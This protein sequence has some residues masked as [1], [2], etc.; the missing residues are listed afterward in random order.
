MTPQI[1]ILNGLFASA[2]GFITAA[3]GAGVVAILAVIVLV[4]VGA[5]AIRKIAG[6]VIVIAILAAVF[7][8]MQ[9]N[10][11]S[12]V[13]HIISQVQTG[14]G[15]TLDPTQAANLVKNGKITIQ[16]GGKTYDISMDTSGW[17][18]VPKVVAR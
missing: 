10:N 9:G 6:V 12:S 13:T 16:S 3:G 17:I 5:R 15:I 1:P 7:F 2:N 8:F 11:A 14:Q 18:P 4:F